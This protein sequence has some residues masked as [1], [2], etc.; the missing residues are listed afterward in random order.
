M[1]EISTEITVEVQRWGSKAEYVSIAGN[2]SNS[3]DFHIAFYIGQIAALHPNTRFH[4]GS[5]QKSNFRITRSK[6]DPRTF[7]V[8]EGYY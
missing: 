5:K 8:G 1:G 3:L 6:I 4:I 7:K 2:G